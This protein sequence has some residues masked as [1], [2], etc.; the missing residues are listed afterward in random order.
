MADIFYFGSMY[1]FKKNKLIF[2]LETGNQFEFIKIAIEN[3][4]P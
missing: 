3:K 1:F 4:F 2:V